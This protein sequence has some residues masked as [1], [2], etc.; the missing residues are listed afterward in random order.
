MG[1]VG[2]PHQLCVAC[3]CRVPPSGAD[4]FQS[5]VHVSSRSFLLSCSAIF[6]CR[7]AGFAADVYEMEGALFFVSDY[8]ASVAEHGLVLVY[9]MDWTRRLARR[10]HS[11]SHECVARVQTLFPA[12]CVCL[13]AASIFHPCRRTTRATQPSEWVVQSPGGWPW[14][15]RWVPPLA[16][17]LR[18]GRSG[19]ADFNATW[20]QP[21]KHA[22][23]Y[24]HASQGAHAQLGQPLPEPGAHA[25]GALP[26]SGFCRQLVLPM[27]FPAS[28][29]ML[30]L[31]A[32]AKRGAHFSRLV[33]PYT[34][35]HP[36]LLC[37]SCRR[38]SSPRTPH[39]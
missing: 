8:T 10:A 30:S 29:A 36:L 37:P 4:S 22:S 19:R 1:Q 6:L 17:G 25:A 7:L 18:N 24:P 26:Q 2:V 34:L 27:L 5:V 11:H 20:V 21:T 12:H 39:S 31:K 28:C 35:P 33:G 3:P 13:P 16:G 9:C 38:C 23:C 14:L 15:A 32:R